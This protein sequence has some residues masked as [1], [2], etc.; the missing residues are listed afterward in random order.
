MYGA[1]DGAMKFSKG[2]SI[3]R[4]DHR[5]REYRGRHDH[6]HHPERHG[7]RG[8]P[9]H[10]R[11]PLTIGD[12]LV[13]QIPSLLISISAGILITRT[14]D[15]DDNV[16]SQIGV[17]ISLAKALLMAGGLVPLRP[18]PGF[19]K[20]NCSRWRPSSAGSAMCSKRVNPRNPPGPG[21]QGRTLQVPH[22]HGPAPNPPH[23][24]AQD[25]VRPTVPIIL[26]ISVD[27]RI[28]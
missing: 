28:S 27:R 26:D 7:R 15:S 14:G 1:M 25:E 20:R 5:R 8:R 10:L 11:H 16:G 12:G 9:A 19:P 22:A 6:R 24:A 18:R 17:Q 2:D 3:A 4:D 13:S 23:G 21:R